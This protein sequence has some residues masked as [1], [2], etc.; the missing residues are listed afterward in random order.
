MEPTPIC[1][2]ELTGSVA[3]KTA[4]ISLLRDRD[5]TYRVWR[6]IGSEGDGFF[7]DTVVAKLDSPAQALT[8]FDSSVA[9]Q[10]K[11]GF[12]A[13]PT[14]WAEHLEHVYSYCPPFGPSDPGNCLTPHQGVACVADL[15][16]RLEEPDTHVIH[17]DANSPVMACLSALALSRQLPVRWKAHDLSQG[18]LRRIASAST[19]ETR[20][21]YQCL[22]V[23]A[24]DCRNPVPVRNYAAAITGNYGRGGLVL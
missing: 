21:L 23:L 8:A 3:G 11:E 13:L 7:N 16:R 12:S 4:R 24:S 22:G 20:R 5:D 6:S 9:G 17:A 1:T 2:T 18:E 15:L 10:L 19:G 14:V